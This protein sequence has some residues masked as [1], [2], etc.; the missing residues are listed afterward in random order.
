V[1]VVLPGDMRACGRVALVAAN[2]R[3]LGQHPVLRPERV[4]P[5]DVAIGVAHRSRDDRVKALVVILQMLELTWREIVRIF[6]NVGRL[7]DVGH[8][9]IGQRDL[10]AVIVAPD[11]ERHLALRAVRLDQDRVACVVDELHVLAVAQPGRENR[12]VKTDGIAADVNGVIVAFDDA[13]AGAQRGVEERC[14]CG[15]HS[16][17]RDPLGRVEHK[18]TVADER[19]PGVRRDRNGDDRVDELEHLARLDD[20][21][22]DP[23]CRNGD[24]HAVAIEDAGDEAGCPFSE[25][26]HVSG[27][28]RRR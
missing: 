27:H 4:V 5:D 28:V 26:R 23:L 18:L 7:H 14:R 19:A 15:A 6:E 11:L 13:Q 12:R 22:V 24:V 10:T 1:R 25:K 21:A 16:T 9:R 17:A 2:E 8:V 20:G 3:D